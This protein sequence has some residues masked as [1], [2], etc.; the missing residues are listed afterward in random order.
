M[1]ILVRVLEFFG[2]IAVAYA[3]YFIINAVGWPQPF[4]GMVIER[5]VIGGLIVALG[6]ALIWSAFKPKPKA[7]ARANPPMAEL[8]A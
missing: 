2:G 4:Q 7:R 8:G 5:Q 6:L 3:G 1:G